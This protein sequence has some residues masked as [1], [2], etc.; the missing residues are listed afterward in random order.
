MIPFRLLQAWRFVT[1]VVHA[2]NQVTDDSFQIVMGL[3][4]D[5]EAVPEMDNIDFFPSLHQQ[6]KVSQ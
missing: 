1:F 4:R 5:D 2:G 3:F 6:K